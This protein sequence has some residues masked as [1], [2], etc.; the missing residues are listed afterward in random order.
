MSQPNYT[1]LHRQVGSLEELLEA[2]EAAASRPTSPGPTQPPPG[3]RLP[4]EV[5]APRPQSQPQPPTRPSDPAATRSQA[6][7]RPGGPPRPPNPAIGGKSSRGAAGSGSETGISSKSKGK[8]G[9]GRL[10][11]Q[12]AGAFGGLGLGLVLWYLGGLCFNFTAGSFQLTRLNPTWLNYWPWLA[13]GLI[14]YVQAV[15]LPRSLAELGYLPWYVLA[16]VVTLTTIDLAGSSGGALDF[17]A[18]K[19][20]R[21]GNWSMVLQPADPLTLALSLGCGLVIS[22]GAEPVTRFFWHE[23]LD[24]A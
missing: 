21:W 5:E 2:E 22:L 7:I 19:S 17:W 12:P 15:Y 23:L 24:R 9:K 6:G 18:G 20:Y 13:Y 14:S 4:G 16:G 10:A 11:I 3:N 8:V 1:R